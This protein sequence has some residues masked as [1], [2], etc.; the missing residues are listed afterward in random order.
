VSATPADYEYAMAAGAVVEQIVRPTG[1]IDP[2]IIVRPATHQ[3]DDLHR[4]ITDCKKR[5]ERVLVTTLTKRTA[6]DLTEYYRELGI[7]VQY[8]HSDVGTLERMQII[9]DLRLGQ[10]DVLV[11]IN[12]LREGLDIP[13]VGLVAIFDADKEGF[14]RSQRSLIQTFGR[15]AR[16][17]SGRVILYADTRT[18]SMA[19]AIEETERRRS[20]QVQFNL[21]HRITPKSIQKSIVDLFDGYAV[22]EGRADSTVAESASDYSSAENIADEVRRL[23]KEMRAAAQDLDFEHAAVLR[24]RIAKLK[25]YIIL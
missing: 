17:V 25:Q 14:L 10:F 20:I 2:E 19:R 22:A 3:V 5:G 6:E 15:A 12:L 11:G 24:D 18:P 13:E 9:R 21:E 8:L 16:N 23:E 4:E 7:L 1:L